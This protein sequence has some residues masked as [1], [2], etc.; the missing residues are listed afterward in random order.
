[1]STGPQTVAVPNV[2]GQPRDT[3]IAALTGAGLSVQATCATN[4]PIVSQNPP[5]GTQVA[6]NTVVMIACVA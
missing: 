2:V 4:S 5:A 6:P 3:G 1:V